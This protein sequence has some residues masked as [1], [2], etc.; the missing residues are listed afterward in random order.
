MGQADQCWQHRG[1][2]SDKPL[3]ATTER[4]SKG[5]HWLRCQV[6]H[7]AACSVF[8]PGTPLCPPPPFKIFNQTYQQGNIA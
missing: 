8:T 5:K 6:L 7:Y 1:T 4:T 2:R 3:V